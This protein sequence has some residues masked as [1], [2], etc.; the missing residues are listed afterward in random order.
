M[1]LIVVGVFWGMCNMIWIC[2]NNMFE[3]DDWGGCEYIKIV[4]EYGKL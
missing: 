2:L 3:M 1:D 4:I